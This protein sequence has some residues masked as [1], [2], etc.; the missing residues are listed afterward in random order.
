MSI[1]TSIGEQKILSPVMSQTL[2]GGKE[3][4]VLIVL[5][6]VVAGAGWMLSEIRRLQIQNEQVTKQLIDETRLR[7]NHYDD[8]T[9]ELRAAEHV[10]A[11][12]RCKP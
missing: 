4:V 9:I 12:T 5:L 8:M 1:T 3:L 6:A 7:K 2:T 10:V 11:M